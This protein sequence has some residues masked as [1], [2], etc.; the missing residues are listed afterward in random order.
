MLLPQSTAKMTLA[1]RAN[2]GF[3]LHLKMQL[4]LKNGTHKEDYVSSFAHHHQRVLCPL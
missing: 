3:L 2:T 1:G 4:L